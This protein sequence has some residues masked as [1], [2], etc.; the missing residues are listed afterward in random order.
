VVPMDISEASRGSIAEPG[1][2][3]FVANQ[4]I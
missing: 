4:S 1:M 3:I 2:E